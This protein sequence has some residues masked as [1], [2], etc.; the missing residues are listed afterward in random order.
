MHHG[1]HWVHLGWRS[2]HHED[3]GADGSCTG[4]SLHSSFNALEH[5]FARENWNEL[6]WFPNGRIRSVGTVYAYFES[7]WG[8]WVSLPITR[9]ILLN[10]FESHSSSAA[11]SFGN[12][13]ISVYSILAVCGSGWSHWFFNCSVDL[14]AIEA[15]FTGFWCGIFVPSFQSILNV[16]LY[17]S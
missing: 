1:W 15:S 4:S 5:I 11:S 14:C 17:S 2:L 16:A 12:V 9:F 6:N 10:W 3:G 13:A 8:P 7:G